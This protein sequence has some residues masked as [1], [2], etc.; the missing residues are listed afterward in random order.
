MINDTKTLKKL[1]AEQEL[2]DKIWSINY[3]LEHTH[4]DTDE[5]ETY[6]VREEELKKTLKKLKAEQNCIKTKETG[7]TKEDDRRAAQKK[8]ARVDADNKRRAKKQAESDRR[9]REHA[10]KDRVASNKAVEE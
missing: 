5:E 7:E 6:G 9:A 3:D 4:F 8:A 10:A 2:K 1:K